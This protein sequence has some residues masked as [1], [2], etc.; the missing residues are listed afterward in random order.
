[1]TTRS[2]PYAMPYA[3]SSARGGGLRRGV[4]TFLLTLMAIVVFMASFAVGYARVNEG[5]VLPGVSVDGVS[6]AGL[7]RDQA[8]TKLQ[9]SLPNLAA[10]NLAVDI[11]GSSKSVPY[12]TFKRAYD[13]S[14][15]LDQAFGLGRATNFVQQI[16]EQLRVL[17]NGVD[18]QPQ[19]SW[20]SQKLVDEVAAMAQAAQTDPVSAS[21]NRVDGHYVVSP[22]QTGLSV[23][24]QGAVSDALAAVNSTSTA[25]TQI[26]VH[27]SVVPPVITTEQAQAAA[28][29][30]ERVI[31]NGLTVSGGNISAQI[32]ADELRGW[33][34]LNEAPT[35]G[36]WQVVI[37]R[38]PIEQFVKDVAFQTDVAATNATFKFDGGT[39]VNV[40]V[41]PSADGQATDV[42][43]TTDSIMAALQARA[44]GA[45][46]PDTVQLALGSVAPEF[47]TSDAQAI[48]SKVT[49][50]G[51]W[52]THYIAGPL[53]GGGVNIQIPTSIINGYVVEPGQLFDFLNVIGPI[54]SPPY[55]Q[56]AAII[57]GHTVEEG[58]LGGG[59]CSCS[60]TLFNAVMRAGLDIHQ[61]R[62]HT[63]YISRYPV[64]LDATVWIAGPNSKQTMSFVNDLQ[65]PILIKGIN[66]PNA[67]TFNVYGVPDG[68]TVELS[69]PIVTNQQTAQSYFEYTNSLPPGQ[70][71]LV[72]F[73]VNGFDA[74]VTRTVRDAS[75]NILH[76]DTWVSNYKTIDGLQLVGRFPGD[77]P[78]GT[79]VLASAWHAAHPGPGTTTG[80]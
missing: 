41:V 77:P 11:N 61:R 52:T 17:M 27:T 10:G 9:S 16:Q 30:V 55:T 29:T 26:T 74:S 39:G 72:E 73:V 67:V 13:L 31:G 76:Q 18:I 53:N 79:K 71:N 63:Y 14:F 35:G 32:T 70:K 15:M 19:V 20:D 38:D 24:V 33:V 43:T 23:D 40:T 12:S 1:M 75:G 80:G 25:D 54:T 42:E 57:H 78:E 62:N 36:D 45:T 69:T 65:Y 4:F 8:A 21:L 46:A 37:Q 50:I 64:G 7:S 6:L 5:K 48:S 58:V 2:D 3:K 60:T 49:L 28:D 59:M 47:T 22:A 56:G 34:Y 68:R 51:T 66:A 44:S